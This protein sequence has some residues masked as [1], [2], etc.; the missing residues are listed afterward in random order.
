MKAWFVTAED[1]KEVTLMGIPLFHV[2]GMI[3]GM[4]FA[5]TIGSSMVMVPN[6]RDLKDVL[7]NISKFKAT[8]FP[9]VPLLYNAIN[10]HP[11]VKAGK[12]DL[13]FFSSRIRHTRF[14]C[15]WSSDVC[16]SDLSS[17]QSHRGPSLE[18]LGAPAAGKPRRWCH[19]RARRLRRSPRRASQQPE[20]QRS[21]RARDR[22]HGERQIGRASCRD[23]E[24][25]STDGV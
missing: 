10:N 23:R 19:L 2:Y 13:F 15:D 16:S 12:Y 5:M 24:V 3:A 18:R 1:G 6:A 25:V 11:D 8:L 9:G 7:Q 22:R 20:R 14:D 21:R 17:A 4:A